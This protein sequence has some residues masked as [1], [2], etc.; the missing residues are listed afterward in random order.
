MN[1]AEINVRTWVWL[2]DTTVIENVEFRPAAFSQ[3]QPFGLSVFLIQIL[4]AL[5]KAWPDGSVRGLCARG[6][7][8]VDIAWH[9]GKLTSMTIHSLNGNPIRLRYGQ[10]TKLI[11][12]KPGKTTEWDGTP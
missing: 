7:L 5:P 1:L 3:T 11:Q 9:V 8:V 2:A 6:G 10:A 4:P 12:L